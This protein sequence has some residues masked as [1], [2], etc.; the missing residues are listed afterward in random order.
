MKR[1]EMRANSTLLMLTAALVVFGLA[2]CG[3]H[4]KTA[5][6]STT[7]S[8]TASRG[9][10]FD[11]GKTIDYGSFGTTTDLDC[12]DGKSLNVGGS[13]NALIVK[14]T[15]SSVRI[16]GTDNKITVDKIV[17]D[18]SVGGFNNTITYKAGDP[19]VHNIGS[20]NTVNKG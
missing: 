5:T 19:K 11:I 7:G 14:G 10:E 17:K 12:G 6:P 18:L 15:C 4:T 16:A 13:N 9:A 3:S 20:G 1:G 8:T 2:G